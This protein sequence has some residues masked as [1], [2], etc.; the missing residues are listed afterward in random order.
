[1][2]ACCKNVQNDYSK[3]FLKQ[4]KDKGHKTQESNKILITFLE[5]NSKE[6]ELFDTLN[7]GSR[8]YK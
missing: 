8:D 4:C 1:M 7:H 6:I 2:I 5:P 3:R